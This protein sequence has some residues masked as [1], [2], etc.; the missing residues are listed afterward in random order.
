MYVYIIVFIISTFF[1]YMAK[2][3]ENKKGVSII[4]SLLAIS[5]PSVLAGMRNSNIGTD[6]R[7]YGIPFFNRAVIS[8]SF[9]GYSKICETE[10]GYRIVNYIVSRFTNNINVFLFVVSFITFGLVYSSFY[11][12]RQKVS[13]WLCWICYLFLF[14]NRFLNLLRQ[15]IAV[16]IIMYAYK[17]IENKNWKKYLVAVFVAFIF[18]TTAIFAITLIFIDK[19]V[20]CKYR[21]SLIILISMIAIILILN[22]GNILKILIYNMGILSDRYARYIPYKKFSF[23]VIETTILGI[24]LGISFLFSKGVNGKS[25]TNMFYLVTGIFGIILMQL[26]GIADYADRIAFYYT[27]AYPI[28]LASIPDAVGKEETDKVA[29]KIFIVVLF[30]LYWGWKY[31]YMGS[32]ETYPYMSDILKIY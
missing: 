8:K 21:N 29:L 18:H 23:Q 16:S 32:C 6:V 30:A 25:Q 12:R 22:Y 9:I 2:K 19:I 17:Y 27:G 28:L 24:L 31:I 10:L 3:F 1:A 7:V 14:Y 4:F 5:V 26:S 20:E 11:Q 15:G 13:L